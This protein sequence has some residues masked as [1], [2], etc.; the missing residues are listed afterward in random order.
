MTITAEAWV[1]SK[2]VHEGF[3]VALRLVLLR[4]LQF[5]P[6]SIIHQGFILMLHSLPPMLYD[7]SK[8]QCCKIKQFTLFPSYIIIFL[9]L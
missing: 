6:S 9:K 4:L 3:V 8:I 1:Q 2:P 5:S 7:L